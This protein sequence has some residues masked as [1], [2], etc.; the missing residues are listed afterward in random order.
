MKKMNTVIAINW[1][2]NT[3]TVS[4]TD[5]EDM[6]YMFSIGRVTTLS[7]AKARIRRVMFKQY[8]ITLSRM[9]FEKSIG[10]IDYYRSNRVK[11]N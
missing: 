11:E 4:F 10:D 8:G 5:I 6:G 2:C 9:R 1:A 3:A 7:G